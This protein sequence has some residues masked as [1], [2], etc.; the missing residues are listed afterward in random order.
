MKVFKN[1][2]QV[3]LALLVM[4]VMIGCSKETDEDKVGDAQFCLDDLPI[5]GLSATERSTKINSCLDKL[6]SVNNK[7]SN[8]VKCAAG[9]MIE[10]FADPAK[11]V[12]IAEEMDNADNQDPTIALMS[13]LIFKSQGTSDTA[14]TTEDKELAQKT[15]N[16]CKASESS[17]YLMLASV[18]NMATVI[19][20]SIGGIDLSAGI[21]NL[22]NNPGALTDASA[23]VIGATATAAYQ[24]S[25]ANGNDSNSEICTQLGAAITSNGGDM[26]A[27]G[28]SLLA[29]W[30]AS[31]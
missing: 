14:S 24:T 25:C 30:Q 17:G 1:W 18:A 27:I 5:T 19:A 2:N 16:Y 26:T 15:F 6:G 20:A 13:V 4:P 11:L 22:V 23:E 12:D 10:G 28:T 21:D 7:Q 8:L 3:L 31:Q 29:T 9:F